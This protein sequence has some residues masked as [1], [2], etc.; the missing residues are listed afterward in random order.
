MPLHIASGQSSLLTNDVRANESRWLGDGHEVI[1]LKEG[2]N[3]NTSIFI[4]TPLG[5]L[6]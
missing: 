4:H 5:H 6:S 2:E 1:W 3:D